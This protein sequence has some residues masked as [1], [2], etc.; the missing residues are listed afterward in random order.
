MPVLCSACRA[1]GLR[2]PRLCH[3]GWLPVE[4]HPTQ[5]PGEGNPWTLGPRQASSSPAPSHSS[6][7]HQLLGSGAALPVFSPV[8]HGRHLTCCH[9]SLCRQH[10]SSLHTAGLPIG[11]SQATKPGGLGGPQGQRMRLGEDLCNPPLSARSASATKPS[12]EAAGGRDPSGG[13]R[14]GEAAGGGPGGTG[15]SPGG[16]SGRKLG[17]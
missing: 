6:S 14:P 10:T 13:A 4:P 7:L 16:A 3:T 9:S 2:N 12:R 1:T 15:G 17:G 8:T 11:R 5:K